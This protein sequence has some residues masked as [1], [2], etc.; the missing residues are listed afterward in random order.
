M[1]LPVLIYGINP[2]AVD[3]NRPSGRIAIDDVK[4]TELF[5]LMPAETPIQILNR[6]LAILEKSFPQYARSARPYIPAGRQRAMQ[7]L[8]DIAVAEDSLARQVTDQIIAMGGLT[9]SGDYPM[10]Y[11]DTHDLGIDYMVQ[12]AIGYMRQDIAELERLHSE[13]RAGAGRPRSRRGN[14]QH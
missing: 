2:V 6:V 5:F 4:L 8:Q 10:E 14:P 13:A 12:E 7:T 3:R 1:A 9:D 11:T